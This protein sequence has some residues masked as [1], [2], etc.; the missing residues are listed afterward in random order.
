M[1]SRRGGGVAGDPHPLKR[2][3]K[4]AEQDG[5]SASISVCI[6]GTAGPRLWW[7]RLAHPGLCWCILILFLYRCYFNPL[8]SHIK[9]LF[10]QNTQGHRVCAL[11]DW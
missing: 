2:T 10:L 8:F 3:L 4:A 7:L 5:G 9:L 11:C 1:F 6:G